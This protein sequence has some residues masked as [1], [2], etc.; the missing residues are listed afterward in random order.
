MHFRLTIA[1]LFFLVLHG[2]SQNGTISGVITEESNGELVIGAVVIVDS[3]PK[4]GAVTDF[5][6]KYSIKI[7]AGVYTITCHFTGYAAQSVTKVKVV[8]G[9]N[10]P[11]DFLLSTRLDS[12]VTIYETRQ[13]GTISAVLAHSSRTPPCCRPSTPA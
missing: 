12:V 11:L 2:F 5:D 13:P 8:A 4:Y 7:P 10:T 9:K 6:G 1:A 3:L